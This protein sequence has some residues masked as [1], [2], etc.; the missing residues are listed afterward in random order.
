[1]YRRK[2][3]EEASARADATMFVT[4]IFVAA[5]SIIAM[6]TNPF[7]T[8]TSVGDMAPDLEGSVWDGES[9][10]VY[11]LED[12]IN[13]DWEPGLPG[14]WI[15]VEFMD[16]NCGH[17]QQAAQD[18]FPPA[19]DYWFGSSSPAP[20]EINVE[21]LA[22]S[23]KLDNPG[24]K[25][26]KPEIQEFR[27]QYSHEFNYMDG[28]DNVFRDIWEVQGT[29]SYFLIAPNGIVKYSSPEGGSYEN[30]WAAMDDLIPS[31]G[32]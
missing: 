21:F 4:V 30:V 26:G 15:M 22:V 9:W 20:A 32:Q 14:T 31:G 11:K 23:I 27:S 19:Q 17:C 29:P 7:Y 1:M 13:T 16:T 2:I 28:Q 24:W 12:R 6:T 8:G 5:Y 25:Y 18:N 10:S 3:S